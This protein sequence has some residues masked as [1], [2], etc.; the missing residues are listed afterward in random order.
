MIQ[1]EK[2]NISIIFSIIKISIYIYNFLDFLENRFSS[3]GPIYY[4]YGSMV[5]I[6]EDL[7]TAVRALYTLR[8]TKCEDKHL[9][10]TFMIFIYIFFIYLR[11]EKVLINFKIEI[12]W[13]LY[14]CFIF[15]Y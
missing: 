14:A 6:Y 5:I 4:E 15:F 12:V 3:I 7:D 10:G 13:W 9:L 8:E 1:T 11:C 2:I